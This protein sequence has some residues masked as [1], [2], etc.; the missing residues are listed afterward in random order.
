L[1]ANFDNWIPALRS[2]LRLRSVR[3]FA[4]HKPPV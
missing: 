1:Q 4:Q 2:T 3:R